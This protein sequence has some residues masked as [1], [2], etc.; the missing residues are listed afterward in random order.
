MFF[1]EGLMQTL[2]TPAKPDGGAPP[3]FAS[4]ALP[5]PERTSTGLG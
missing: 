4:R 5:A 3:N 2:P 1:L